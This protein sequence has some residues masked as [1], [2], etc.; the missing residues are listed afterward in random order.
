L[1]TGTQI[2]ELSNAFVA[3]NDVDQFFLLLCKGVPSI[4][5][6]IDNPKQCCKSL[7]RL[8]PSPRLPCAMPAGR[9]RDGAA[10]ECAQALDSA[11]LAL[12]AVL[13]RKPARGTKESTP[14]RAAAALHSLSTA[15]EADRDRVAAAAGSSAPPVAAVVLSDAVLQQ[16]LGCLRT[17]DTRAVEVV[18]R[19]ACVL[20]DGEFV[21]HLRRRGHCH[22]DALLRCRRGA[23][24]HSDATPQ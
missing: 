6:F 2:S 22:T 12:V 9:A 16:L 10:A 19:A 8:Q 18:F 13:R 21:M 20:M 14:Q 7:A 17:T 11:V 24:R 4:P 5:Y 3:C 15:A 23:P 1:Q